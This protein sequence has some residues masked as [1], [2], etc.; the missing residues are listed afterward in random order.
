[1]ASIPLFPLGNALFPDGIMHLRVF[2]VR[3][4]DMVRQCIADGS[5]FGVVPLLE[6]QEVR[7]PEGKEVLAGAG[8]L[9]RIVESSAP[10]PGLLQIVC[11]G[12]RRFRLLSAE[13]GR[14]GLWTGEIEILPDDPA[15]EIP[16]EL[17][18]C[19]NALGALIADLQRRATPTALMPVVPPFRLDE[20]GW[21]A[22][23]WSEILPLAP[24][25]KQDLLLTAD[26]E[27]RLA[28]IH[29]LLETR[30]LL[31]P[32]DTSPPI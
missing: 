12:T 26:P 20:C 30:G 32:P 18:A 13:Q 11:A 24:A 16:Q 10:M 28:H 8:T 14:F 9:A 17:Q 29:D 7:T 25:M 27:L 2:E 22:D 23:R 15:R 21:V 31:S 4:L 6:G 19:A 3:Y 5:A 1:M